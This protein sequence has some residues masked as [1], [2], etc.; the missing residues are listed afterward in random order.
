[1]VESLAPM[2]DEQRARDHGATP[3]GGPPSPPRTPA[4]LCPAITE[5]VRAQFQACSSLTPDLGV[6]PK[7]R[8]P[9]PVCPAITEHVRS[10]P[11]RLSCQHSYFRCVRP[12]VAPASRMT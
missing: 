12:S 3:P 7:T 6:H 1:M 11:S 4:P 5:H 8:T 2:W 9:L 10:M